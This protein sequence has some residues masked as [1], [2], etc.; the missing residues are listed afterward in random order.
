[1]VVLFVSLSEHIHVCALFPCRQLTHPP[2]PLF[3]L[4][5]PTSIPDGPHFDHE[6]LI[7]KVVDLKEQQLALRVEQVYQLSAGLACAC[8]LCTRVIYYM[9]LVRTFHI[10]RR[11]CIANF[12]YPLLPLSA[13]SQRNVGRA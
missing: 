8:A 1:M 10:L 7:K 13:D 9:H 5:P 12:A 3:F 4:H 6:A 2:S 11:T